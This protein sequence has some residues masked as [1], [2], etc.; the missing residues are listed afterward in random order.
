MAAFDDLT[1]KE[2][3]ELARIVREA[4][5][6]NAEVFLP[7]F[8]MGS[9]SLLQAVDADGQIDHAPRESGFWEHLAEGRY[10]F[11]LPDEIRLLPRAYAYCRYAERRS[12]GRL[13]IDL[14]Y[15]LAHDDTVRS[16]L[17]WALLA[18]ALS[19]GIARLFDV[20]LAP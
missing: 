7:L 12:L 5:A 1:T 16:K 20:F 18:V 13:L 3:A 4:R 15:D 17:L 6:L 8:L 19:S 11:V 2:G 9:N 10:L 14:R